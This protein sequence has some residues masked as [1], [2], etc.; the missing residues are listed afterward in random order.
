MSCSCQ[1]YRVCDAGALR[2]EPLATLM[3]CAVKNKKE[4]NRPSLG[5]PKRPP[6]RNTRRISR[7]R[8]GLAPDG[9]GANR[10]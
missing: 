1:W 10:P 2:A 8:G 7:G 3:S 5:R 9:W 4:E 6:R